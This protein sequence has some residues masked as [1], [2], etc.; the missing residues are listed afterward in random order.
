KAKDGQKYGSAGLSICEGPVWDKDSKIPRYYD[1]EYQ[2]K[3]GL[4][5]TKVSRGEEKFD[6]EAFADW[7]YDNF[8]ED[9]YYVFKHYEEK[10]QEEPRDRDDNRG[11]GRDDDRRSSRDNDREERGRNDDRARDSRDD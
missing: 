8:I 4:D 10:P 3:K 2:E 9:V 7:L 5:F 1:K 11:R 6:K